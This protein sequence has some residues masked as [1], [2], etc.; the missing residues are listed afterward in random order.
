MLDVDKDEIRQNWQ[1]VHGGSNGSGLAVCDFNVDF[2]PVSQ[3]ANESQMIETRQFNVTEVARYFS[4]SPVLLQDLSH[5]S[6]STIDASQLEFLTHTLLPYIS[7]M[8]SEF[9]RKLG[10]DGIV[11]DLDGKYLM[12]ADKNTEANYIKNLISSGVIC[13]NEGRRMLG[14]GPIEGGDKHIIAYTNI[15]NNTINKDETE[16]NND[17]SNEDNLES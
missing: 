1:Q 4:I 6:Y 12:S 10:E 11:I 14:L 13:I 3:S 2:I 8:E 15:D 7:L 16:P 5:S 17:V 9:N